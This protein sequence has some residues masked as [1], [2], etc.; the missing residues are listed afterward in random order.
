M[1][2]GR[3][4][5]SHDDLQGK[6]MMITSGLAEAVVYEDAGENGN[7]VS[8][9]VHPVGS[10][11]H[12]GPGHN[13]ERVPLHSI[14][15]PG[16]ILG[17]SSFLQSR[18]SLPFRARTQV[19]VRIVKLNETPV[20]LRLFSNPTAGRRVSGDVMSG[21]GHGLSLAAIVEMKTCSEAA[22]LSLVDKRS[23]KYFGQNDT[24]LEAVTEVAENSDRGAWMVRKRLNLLQTDWRCIEVDCKTRAIVN[25]KAKNLKVKKVAQADGKLK[26]SPVV[27]K[28]QMLDASKADERKRLPFDDLMHVIQYSQTSVRVTLTFISKQKPYQIY[29]QDVTARDDFLELLKKNLNKK[30]FQTRFPPEYDYDN[31][32]RLED[33][34]IAGVPT[35]QDLSAFYRGLAHKLALQLDRTQTECI[36]LSL[37]KALTDTDALMLLSGGSEQL[38]LDIVRA[39]NLPV[40]EKIILTCKCYLTTEDMEMFGDHR[41]H[42][43]LVLMSNYLIMDS[44]IYGPQMD[45]STAGSIVLRI[46]QIYEVF[47]DTL[48]MERRSHLFCVRVLSEDGCL[49]VWQ[50]AFAIADNCLQVRGKLQ[51]FALQGENLRKQLSESA[52]HDPDVQR[53]MKKCSTKHYLDKGKDLADAQRTDSFFIILKGEVMQIGDKLE[54]RI[55]RKGFCFGETGFV[56]GTKTSYFSVRARSPSIVL[57]IHRNFIL[58]LTATDPSLGARF[59]FAICKNLN[60]EINKEMATMFPG[61]WS[62]PESAKECEKE[63]E[64]SAANKKRLLKLKSVASFNRTQSAV[65]QIRGN[66]PCNNAS[67]GTPVPTPR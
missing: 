50:L 31:V 19:S 56:K 33:I 12:T 59:W 3:I 47:D 8:K 37:L 40:S 1:L 20:P 38:R 4:F 60:I 9:H 48:N 10:S 25:K 15:G 63:D 54:Y 67:R 24:E 42:M 55:L 6:L 13:T 2:A 16:H 43:R 30:V 17:V 62:T 45:H 21:E 64:M 18:L 46:D 26:E 57:E 14:L 22:S 11:V 27:T 23:K 65:K 29:F 52:F 61:T 66:N 41:K 7:L 49:E 34:E 5:T 44:A 36:R 39:L 53:L 28:E 51:D 35:T 58:N 32:I